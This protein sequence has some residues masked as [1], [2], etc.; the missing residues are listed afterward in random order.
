M[1][2]DDDVMTIMGLQLYTPGLKLMM[3]IMGLQLY[4]P[5]LK[6]MC[7]AIYTKMFGQ[8]TIYFITTYNI[9]GKTLIITV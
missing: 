3:T 4:T 2:L 1:A 6:L 9:Q 8:L 5:G 7:G